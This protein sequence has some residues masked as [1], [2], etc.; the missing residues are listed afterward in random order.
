MK[1]LIPNSELVIIEGAGHAITS[2]A[3]EEL[4]NAIEKF[5]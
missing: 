1:E 5:I 3:P 2:E 4:N